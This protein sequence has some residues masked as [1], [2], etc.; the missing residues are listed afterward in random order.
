MSDMKKKFLDILEK[1][2]IPSKTKE[3]ISELREIN[4]I[5]TEISSTNDKL[6]KSD[7]SKIGNDS[8][9]LAS[10]YGKNV[11]DYLSAVQKASDAGYADAMGIAELSVAAQNAGGITDELADKYLASADKAYNFG[12]SVQ[13]LT[14]VLEGSYSIASQNAIHMAELAEGMSI[15]ST[16]AASLGIG[17]DETAAV[18]GTMIATTQQSG[19]EAANA[20]KTLLLLLQQVTSEE[21]GIDAEGLARY[22]NACRALN[23]SLRETQNGVTSLRDPMAVIRDL[24]AEYS[25]LDSSDAR[26]INLLDS[27]GG[28]S[29]ADAFQAILENYSLYEEMLQD[30]ANS[31]GSIAEGNEK[32]A[33]SWEGSMNRLSN[34][35]TDT[36]GNFANSDAIIAAI[37]G[38]NSLL[39]VVNTVT[40]KLGSFGSIGLGA[41]LFASMKNFGRPKMSGLFIVEICRI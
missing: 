29:E 14:E 12:G 30:Y 11:K 21:D 17:T 10:K 33:N 3:A 4:T 24:S 25:K 6:S 39:S 41:G 5:L 23:V 34:T 13:K 20:L 37:N 7:L 1:V 27:V 32:I 9:D 28:N 36:V 35:W 8:F 26:K 31:S 38:L 22:E 16:E 18:L 15:A 2:D 19:S 40:D